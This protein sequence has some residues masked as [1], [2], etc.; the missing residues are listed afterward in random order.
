[1]SR[2]YEEERNP[3]R[4]Q[5]I[6]K[7]GRYNMNCPNCFCRLGILPF[8]FSICSICTIIITYAV[9]VA[10]DDVYPFFPAISDTGGI[11]PESNVFGFFLSACAF[12]GFVSVLIRYYQFRFI[13]ENNEEHR[14]RLLCVNKIALILG[15]ISIGGALVVAAFQD[16]GK[17]LKMHIVGALL[18]F[19]FGVLYCFAQTYMTFQML[20]CATNTMRLFIVRLAIAVLSFFFFVCS[21]VFGNYAGDARNKNPPTD[22]SH[23]HAHWYP[24]DAGFVYNVLGNVCEWLMVISFFIY[25]LTFVREFNKVKIGFNMQSDGYDLLIPSTTDYPDENVLV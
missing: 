3:G 21:L 20:L 6:A 9:S 8:L 4:I 2:S 12:L 25:F 22:P 5:H 24:E 10:R 7:G 13:S 23:D 16:R 19:G 14:A 17:S 1:M 15:V 18:V 11:P